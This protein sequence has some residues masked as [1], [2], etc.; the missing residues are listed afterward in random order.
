[1]STTTEPLNEE[2][3]LTEGTGERSTRRLLFLLLAILGLAA[4]GLLGVLLWLL[5][6][7]HPAPP[8]GQAAGY[9]IEVVTTIRGYGSKAAEQIRT[10]LGVTFDPQG[11]VWVADTGQSRVEVYTSDGTHIRNVGVAGNTKFAAPEL[12]EKL[13]L[14]A[15]KAFNQGE[16]NADVAKLQE[17]YGGI[18]YVFADVKAD[19]R[20]LEEPAQ[21][22]L[23]YNIKEGDRYRVGK[24]NVDIKG[25]YPHTQIYTIL[26]R[27]SLH[28]GD[29]VDTREIRASERRIRASGLFESNPATGNAPKLLQEHARLI[30]RVLT[31][32]YEN[33]QRLLASLSLEDRTTLADILRK[34]LIEFEDHTPP[35]PTHVDDFSG[36]AATGRSSRRRRAGSAR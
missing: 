10:P 19:P 16:M 5:R 7:D 23:V 29:I 26:N 34:L 33:E 27:L 14:T 8:P 21:L 28:P 32:H 6:P 35:V 25:E 31:L 12:T 1:M 4:V 15:G 3:E 13:N 11:N 36:A 24:I 22:D 18:G 17:K 20:F 9:P 30:D 2:E